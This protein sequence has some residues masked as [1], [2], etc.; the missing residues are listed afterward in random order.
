MKRRWKKRK[1]RAESILPQDFGREAENDHGEDDEEMIID[2]DD[3]VEDAE[4]EETLIA[5]FLHDIDRVR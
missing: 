5:A 4:T 2:E 3:I 1:I